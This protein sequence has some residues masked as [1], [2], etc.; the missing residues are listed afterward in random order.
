MKQ[1]T[2]AE[3]KK[4]DFVL[5]WVKVAVSKEDGGTIQCVPLQADLR[6]RLT[7]TIRELRRE[8]R[9]LKPVK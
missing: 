9:K 2:E 5:P 7:F 6:D 1:V 4:I 8:N 3:L